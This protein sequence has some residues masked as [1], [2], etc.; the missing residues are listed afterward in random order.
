MMS[1]ADAVARFFNNSPKRQLTLES[2]IESILQGER[3]EKS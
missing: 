1:M 2:W 3:R